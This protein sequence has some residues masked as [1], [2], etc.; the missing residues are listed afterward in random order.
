[1]C[2][3]KKIILTDAELEKV[4]AGSGS[5]TYY[6]LDC[7]WHLEDEGIFSSSI[8]FQVLDH[9]SLGHRVYINTGD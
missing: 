9:K 6:C 5:R 3:D 2:S 8:M 4:A 7:N 1:M